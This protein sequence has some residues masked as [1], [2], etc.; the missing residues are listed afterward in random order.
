[1]MRVMDKLYE[2]VQTKGPVCIGLDTEPSY[3]LKEELQKSTSLEDAVLRYN[4][5]IIDATLDIASVYKVQIAYYEAMGVRGLE[6]Y[7]D[8]LKYLREKKAL[9][10]AD[11]KRGDIAKTAEMYA[12]AHFTG[13]F[14][15]DLIT[16]NPWM[17]MDTL[18]PYYPYLEKRG[19]GVFVLLS[20]SNPGA[21][22]LEYQ[23][24]E[25]G[26]PMW[27][28]LGERLA[29][30]SA[31]FMGEHGYS[32]IGAVVGCTRP[33]DAAKIRSLFPN[34]YFLTPGYGAQGGTAKDL[35]KAFDS[36]GNG[37]V[38]NSSR[39]I[40][41]AYQKEEYRQLKPEEAARAEAIAMQKAFE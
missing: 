36:S 17:G 40:L 7:R 37:A 15:V 29:E 31:A 4:Q 14:E 35:K 21:L 8:T 41:L 30:E 27:Q 10:I 6:V 18:K 1:M 22:D 33:E 13:D 32:S 23:I 19:K 38:V 12:K 16:V 2:S 9:I 26:K 3:I 5:K 24:T 28:V 25:S 34:L 11:I 39:G 20:T